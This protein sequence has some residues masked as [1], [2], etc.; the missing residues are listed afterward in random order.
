MKKH[1]PELSPKCIVCCS[2]LL[3]P[4]LAEILGKDT[5]ITKFMKRFT[6]H[7]VYDKTGDDCKNF[8]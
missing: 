3:S 7:P 5:N 8:I 2:W 1:Y 4:T 6:K